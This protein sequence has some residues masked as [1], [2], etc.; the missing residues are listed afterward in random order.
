MDGPTTH[1]Q[2]A[3]LMHESQLENVF[4]TPETSSV[5]PRSMSVGNEG[6][7]AVAVVMYL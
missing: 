6:M 3:L 1:L 5:M 4:L 2:Y 7:V